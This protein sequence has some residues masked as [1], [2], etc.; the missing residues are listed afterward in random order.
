LDSWNF[1]ISPSVSKIVLSLPSL[2]ILIAWSPPPLD[3]IN[4]KFDGASK[5][6]PRPNRLWRGLSKLF[7]ENSFASLLAVW[8]MTLIMELSYGI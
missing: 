1:N 2:S 8:G 4:V 6:N 3:F 5:G 7:R